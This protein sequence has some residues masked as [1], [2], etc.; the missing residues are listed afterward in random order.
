MVLLPLADDQTQGS[1]KAFFAEVA[2]VGR[3]TW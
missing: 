1:G 3:T 2:L